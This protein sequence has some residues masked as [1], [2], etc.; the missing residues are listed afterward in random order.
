[1]TNSDDVD[2]H[3]PKIPIKF[4]TKTQ[5][6]TN[7]TNTNNDSDSDSAIPYQQPSE[8]DEA[9]NNNQPAPLE[10]YHNPTKQIDNH[11][12]KIFK[13]LTRKPT[14]DDQHT[15]IPFLFDRQ[16]PILSILRD[17]AINKETETEKT[18]PPPEKRPEPLIK[19]ETTQ[20]ADNK[21]YHSSSPQDNELSTQVKMFV[22][23]DMPLIR[24]NQHQPPPT[25]SPGG[26]GGGQP[27][28]TVT[29]LL[30]LNHQQMPRIQNCLQVIS[31]VTSCGSPHP[32]QLTF[33][34]KQPNQQIMKLELPKLQTIK[35][36][37]TN[38]TPP[39]PTVRQQQSCERCKHRILTP[40]S[41][42]IKPFCS[43]RCADFA[44]PELLDSFTLIT[45]KESITHRQPA[46]KY[47]L[48]P[49]KERLKIDDLIMLLSDNAL[50]RVEID[51]IIAPRAEGFRG[52]K[53]KNYSASNARKPSV[54]LTPNGSIVIENLLS[55]TQIMPGAQPNGPLPIPLEQ[56]KG[57]GE[58]WLI[59][60]P[61]FTNITFKMSTRLIKSDEY[62]I[63]Y[64]SLPEQED[65]R[66]CE[67][68][69][70]MGDG[71]TKLEGRL[72]IYDVEQWVHINCIKWSSGITA[73]IVEESP[74][75]IIRLDGFD[76]VLQEYKNNKCEKCGQYGATI[77]CSRTRCSNCYHFP[78]A[79]KGR[80]VFFKDNTMLCAGHA[81][82]NVVGGEGGGDDDGNV[83]QDFSMF[84]TCFVK[85]DVN[86]QIASVI[87]NGKMEIDRDDYGER[88][89]IFF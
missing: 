14:E 40:T 20:P 54:V 63:I 34:P 46:H 87:S 51:N 65:D 61:S 22:K 31:N 59:W 57:F 58:S 86:K 30:K 41:Q 66:I 56:R 27:P 10:T 12:E 24:L 8:A 33:Q 43:T 35:T 44:R 52:R 21:K 53:P 45:T 39:P 11:V 15:D 32:V 13:M 85:R 76:K 19:T 4:T 2:Y 25:S 1:M 77:K 3:Q 64:N 48:R 73:V 7:K 70:G 55:E 82:K 23:S 60:E 67:L 88:G 6:L 84:Q 5:K 9:D 18:S 75:K 17:S 80:C 78:C 37:P 62:P 72:L 81:P 16:V 42:S 36:E 26:G 83:V 69:H 74:S 47:P 89:L 71:L 29:V 49:R 38:K 28:S 68:C 50:K 79:V